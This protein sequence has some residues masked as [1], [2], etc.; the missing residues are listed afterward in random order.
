MK[1]K[2]NQSDGI[3]MRWGDNVD[4]RT[5]NK[6]EPNLVKSITGHARYL[7]QKSFKILSVSN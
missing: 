6:L 4:I 3:I 5:Y 2:K 7:Q 1:T